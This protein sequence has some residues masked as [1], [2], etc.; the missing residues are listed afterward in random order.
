MIPAECCRVL[1]G[2]MILWFLQAVDARQFFVSL[3]ERAYSC[4]NITHRRLASSVEGSSNVTFIILCLEYFAYILADLLW[5][6]LYFGE[7]SVLKQN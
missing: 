5:N 6:G 4:D 2:T 1:R 7:G 3:L